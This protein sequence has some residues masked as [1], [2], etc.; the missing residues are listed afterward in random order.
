[1]LT[2]PMLAV[3]DYALNYQA[4][5]YFTVRVLPLVRLVFPVSS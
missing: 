4:Y 3:S 1:M 2:E 5:L